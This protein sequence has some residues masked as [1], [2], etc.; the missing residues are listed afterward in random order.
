MQGVDIGA[1][2]RIDPMVI[3]ILWPA[4]LLMD[5][6]NGVVPSTCW[7]RRSDERRPSKIRTRIAAH[8]ATSRDREFPV[9]VAD[10][11]AS[12]SMVEA[13]TTLFHHQIASRQRYKNDHGSM[14]L[15]SAD[16]D[17]LHAPAALLPAAFCRPCQRPRQVTSTCRTNG[18]TATC[19]RRCGAVEGTDPGAPARTGPWSRPGPESRPSGCGQLTASRFSTGG[20]SL[21]SRAKSNGAGIRAS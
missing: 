10:P 4:S 16:V 1:C 12:A 2:H 14:R 21:G 20:G 11:P 19:S 18:R 7:R 3:C 17:A 13:Y 15:T 5:E 8:G 6:H 9:G